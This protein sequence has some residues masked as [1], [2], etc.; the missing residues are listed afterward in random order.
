MMDVR[1]TVRRYVGEGL[2]L[3]ILLW[4]ISTVTACMMPEK[5]LMAPT[6]VSTGFSVFFLIGFALL[7]RWIAS[8]KKELLTT[9]YS[10]MSGFRM[11]LALFTLFVCYLVVGRDAMAP[12]VIIF[13]IFYFV[14]VGFH[15]IFFARRTNKE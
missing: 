15:S 7:W 1:N 11:I 3:I 5:N 10:V 4:M 2:L 12:Y 8:S 14:M 9:L 6:W 13:M